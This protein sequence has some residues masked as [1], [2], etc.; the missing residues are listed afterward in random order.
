MAPQTRSRIEGG[1]LIIGAILFF[2]LAIHEVNFIEAVYHVVVAWTMGVV[3]LCT[4][5]NAKDK[6]AL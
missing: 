1:A 5:G 4:I 6:G 2:F 3:G